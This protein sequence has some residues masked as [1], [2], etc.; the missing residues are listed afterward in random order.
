MKRHFSCFG[1]R[2]SNDLMDDSRYPPLTDVSPA[3]KV[4]K[5]V[6]YKLILSLLHVRVD[7]LSL[8]S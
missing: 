7:E 2:P 3:A 5:V 6:I 4:R 1:A 8:W